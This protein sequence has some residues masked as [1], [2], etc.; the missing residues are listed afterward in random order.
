MKTH[1]KRVM[2]M[3]VEKRFGYVYSVGEDGKFKVSDVNSG[4][5]IVDLAPGKS[6]LKQLIFN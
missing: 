3:A 2:G 4:S 6:G 5:I 1:T